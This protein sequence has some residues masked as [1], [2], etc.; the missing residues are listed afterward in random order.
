MSRRRNRRE[1]SITISTTASFKLDAS[2]ANYLLSYCAGYAF[3][4]MK[5]EMY[6][7][8]RV[9]TATLSELPVSKI[10]KRAAEDALSEE[11]DNNAGDNEFPFAFDFA[12]KVLNGA[13]KIELY[14]LYQLEDGGD[15]PDSLI[16]EFSKMSAAVIAAKFPEIHR[17]QQLMV[18]SIEL[19][20]ADFEKRRLKDEEEQ[21]KKDA[22]RLKRM[23]NDADH[24]IAQLNK[25]GYSVTK[26]PA[27]KKSK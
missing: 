15:T 16:A 9:A 6:E 17:A 5:P 27:A 14:D 21:S 23:A 22:A 10:S 13:F 4:G 8:L 11:M 26:S 18:E 2:N 12:K 19:E 20:A 25:L 24:M 3:K 1:K 7:R